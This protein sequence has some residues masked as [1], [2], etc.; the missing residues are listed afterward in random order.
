[1]NWQIK[2]REIWPSLAGLA[3]AFIVAVGLAVI[4]MQA[5]PGDLNDLVRFLLASSIPSLVGGYLV[6]LIGRRWLHSIRLKI[7]LAFGLGIVITLF[8][9]YLTSQLMFV[10]QHDFLLLGLLLIFAG[11]L[12]MSFGYLLANNIAR[13]LRQLQRSADRVAAGDF[14]T[15]VHMSEVDELSRVGDAFNMMADELAASFSRQRELELSRRNLIAAVSHDLRT[16]IASIRAMVEALADGVVSEPE[17]VQRYYANIRAQ[18]QN[19]SSLINDLFELSQLE[20]DQLELE[21]EPVNLNDLLSDVM[22][23]MQAVANA[24]AISMEGIFA[25]DLP[26]VHAEMI[27]IQ[28]VLTNLI[29]NALRHTPEQGTI[30]LCTHALST[31]VQ[32]DVADSGEG[33][34]AED[35]PHIFEQFYRGEKSRSRETGGAGLGLAIAQR[36]IEAHHGQIWVES[37]PG[38]GAKFSFIIPAVAPN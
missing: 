14:S 2:W 11:L 3:A 32:I 17:T 33:V 15:R 34:A 12:S 23:S 6:F 21:L 28:R 26:T 27:K 35:L 9:I 10:S 29:Q 31:G 36:I 16:P 13:S 19:L 38:H 37:E 20:T 24:R 25:A 8:N 1:M 5:P 7:L 18:S 4:V 30:S 22:E